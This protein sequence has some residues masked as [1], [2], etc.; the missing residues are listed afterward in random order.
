[1]DCAYFDAGVCHSCPLIDTPYAQQLDDKQARVRELIGGAPDWEDA[2]ASPEAGFR[3]KAKM[4][5]GGTIGAPTLGILDPEY[6]GVDL[7][8]CPILAPEI[9]A[10]LPSLARFVTEN[11]LEPYDVATRRGELKH[12]LITAGADGQLIVRF[13]LR[14]RRLAA[15]IRRA[16]PDFPVFGI[17]IQPI[18]TTIIE[19]PDDIA[20]TERQRLPIQYGDNTL[21][22]GPRSFV[23]TNTAV[24]RELYATVGRWAAETGARALWDLYCGVGGFAL[25]AASHGLTVEGAEISADAIACATETAALNGLT[26]RFTAGDATEWATAQPAIPDLVVVNP[27][28]RGIGPELADWLEASGPRWVAYSSCYPDSQRADLDR[29]PSYR[30]ARARL[31]DM[32]PHT[33]HAETAVLLQKV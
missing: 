25:A 30:P 9:R 17:N 33:R 2:V 13:V 3:I 28:R 26:A 21:L 32:F 5:V 7:R 16:A 18:H 11:R 24:A 20:V 31:F 12:I 10:A 8:D 19:G 29:M 22:I 4:A 23:Q 6:R 14:S 27:P 15:T 1:M